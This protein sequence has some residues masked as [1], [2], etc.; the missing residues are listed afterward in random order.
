[1][2]KT[3]K[4][5]TIC[6]FLILALFLIWNIYSKNKN[7]NYNRILN[8]VTIGHDVNN[9]GIWD[10]LEPFLES[11]PLVNKTPKMKHYFTEYLKAEKSKYDVWEKTHDAKLLQ[12]AELN[13][14]KIYE[15]VMYSGHLAFGGNSNAKLEDLDKEKD[16]L[17][18]N[19]PD[20][21]SKSFIIEGKSG[22]TSR[23]LMLDEEKRKF[24]NF[25]EE[26]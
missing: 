4:S 20:A 8:E 6:F 25:G 19:S 13:E 14:L 18:Y 5:I 22:L 16:D 21:I 2:K 24:C 1:M 3:L 15:C 26:K 9:N 23:S 17:I 7:K 10:E 11:N 12:A